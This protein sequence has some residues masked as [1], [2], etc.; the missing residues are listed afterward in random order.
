M[1]DLQKL[2]I[3]VELKVTPFEEMGNTASMHVFSEGIDCYTNDLYEIVYENLDRWDYGSEGIDDEL[4]ELLDDNENTLLCPLSCKDEVSFD[5][6]MEWLRNKRFACLTRAESNLTNAIHSIDEHCKENEWS[7]NQ[8][9]T[10][11]VEMH[12]TLEKIRTE[13]YKITTG[14]QS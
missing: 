6:F 4:R 9:K 11:L 1:N 7:S 12:D 2:Y 5:G 10:K 8:L 3:E 13:L 14:E